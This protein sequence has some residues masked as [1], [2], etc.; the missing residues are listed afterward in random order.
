MESYDLLVDLYTIDFSKKECGAAIKRA[1]SPNIDKIVKFVAENFNVSW[2]SEIKAALYKPHPTCYI[3]V[4]DKQ[5]V[6][7]ACYDATAKGFFGPTGVLEEHRGKGIGT[8]LLMHCLEAMLYD[9]YSYAI[10][11]GVRGALEFYKQKC[12][13]VPIENSKNVYKRLIERD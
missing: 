12:N 8:A 1:L 7:F 10:I 5:L 9:G 6:G 11:G 13:A 2:A 3:A 4:I